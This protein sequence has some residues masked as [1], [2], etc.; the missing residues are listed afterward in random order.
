[1]NARQI[2]SQKINIFRLFN[3]LLLIIVLFHYPI[4]GVSQEEYYTYS[5]YNNIDNSVFNDLPDV[6]PVRGGTKFIVTYPDDW[7]EEQQGAFQ[8]AC[9]LWEEVLPTTFPI[10]ISVQSQ[11]R[12]Q[13][14]SINSPLSKVVSSVITPT[15]PW[16]SSLALRTE[17]K[18]TMFMQMSGEYNTGYYYDI[19]DDSYFN[20]N[21]VTITYYEYAD[22]EF[23]DIYSF[24]LD[25]SNVGTKHDF[26]TCA[27]RDIAKGLGFQGRWTV[28]NGKLEV[29]T[30]KMT[31]FM[32]KVFNNLTVSS[33]TG[34][35]AYCN[36]PTSGQLTI[37]PSFNLY[38]PNPWNSGLSLNSFV[39]A[40][41]NALS[42]LLCWNMG[43]GDV[44]RDISDY[45]TYNA[46]KELLDW[47]G[48]FTVGL[49][50]Q[51]TMQQIG[52]NSN[53][54]VAMGGDIVF[55]ISQNA[56]NSISNFPK[57]KIVNSDTQSIKANLQIRQIE[58]GYYTGL[59]FHPAYRSDG[60]TDTQG[61][62]LSVLKKDGTWDIVYEDNV[63][64]IPNITIH[65]SD[66]TFHE[67]DSIYARNYDGRYRFRLSYCRLVPDNL[68]GAYLKT[69]SKYY[70]VG[71]MPQRVKSDMNKC[72]F[73]PEYDHLYD[74]YTGVIK[75]GLKDLEGV[76]RIEVAQ[77]DD[78][79]PIPLLYSVQDYKNGYFNAVVDREFD[80][81]FVITAY[82]ENGHSA[83]EMYT[84][85]PSP[86]AFN[87]A[88]QFER[89]GNSILVKSNSRKNNTVT[90]KSADVNPVL[91]TISSKAKTSMPINKN[92]IDISRLKAGF[93]VLDVEDNENRHYSYKFAK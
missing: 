92:T 41:G 86:N 69:T 8:Y 72:K 64:L 10:R 32:D 13:P 52:L 73:R 61:H 67:P 62:T 60:T 34:D 22:R 14:I 83:S 25:A 6:R 68:Y 4:N 7:S 79:N 46:F 11:K 5:L 48:S 29:N 55:N 80:T 24:S 76:T 17:I 28:R 81:R 36:I 33:W 75:V 35:I 37:R 87:M 39:A 9:E 15:Q 82:N 53:D 51:P 43:S 49:G 65:A 90:L 20:E 47:K 70:L 40:D 19:F 54:V 21:D 84:F 44:C 42:R 71:A 2:I 91:G 66:M 3:N 30:A 1:M 93:Y 89:D 18:A 85:H 38:A 16:H 23:D 50:S 26:I 56:N 88:L 78:W 77:Y 57:E 59:Q 63:G 45:N 27:L 12:N 31:P 58:S 74:E